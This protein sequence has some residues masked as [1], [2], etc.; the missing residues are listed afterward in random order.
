MAKFKQF[1]VFTPAQLHIEWRRMQER[2]FA[3]ACV[4]DT[5]LNFQEPNW[6]FLLLQIHTH[7]GS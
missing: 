4:E 6:H 5:S 7:L 3:M 1:V 2:F